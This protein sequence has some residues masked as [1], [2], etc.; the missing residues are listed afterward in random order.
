MLDEVI[1][2]LKQLQAQVQMLS[3]IGL[4]SMMMPLAIQH[5]LQMSMMTPMGM[6]MGMGVGPAIG[7]DHMNMNVNPMGRPNVAGVPPLMNL[8]AAYNMPFAT[9]TCDGNIA[10]SGDCLLPQGTMNPADPL[11]AYLACQS[12]PTTM[13]AYSRMAAI[14][15]QVQ[16]LQQQSH[17]QRL[18]TSSNT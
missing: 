15:Q 8:A 18:R 2:Y 5:Q 13:D 16:Q 9:T 4:P 7:M 3:R 14:Y 11:S 1:E 17:Q 12:Q 6:G 10:G